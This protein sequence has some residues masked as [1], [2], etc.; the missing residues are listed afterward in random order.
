M[1]YTV[2]WIFPTAIEA[3]A[4]MIP[5]ADSI[6]VALQAQLLPFHKPKA[7]TKYAIASTTSTKPIPTAKR[8]APM[9]ANTIPE[10]MFSIAITVTPNGLCF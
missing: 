2:P 7:I 4:S 9:A 10:I 3:I 5:I 1:G 6:R 8:I